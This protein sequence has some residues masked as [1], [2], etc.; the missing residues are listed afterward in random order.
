MDVL[1][2]EIKINYNKLLKL[3]IEYQMMQNNILYHLYTNKVA[4]NYPIVKYNHM[5]LNYENF[6]NSL[7]PD[8]KPPPHG[9]YN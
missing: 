9:M 2:K 5:A 3:Q 4:L 1:D 7:L 6:K 8:H